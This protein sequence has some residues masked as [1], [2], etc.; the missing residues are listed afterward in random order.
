MARHGKAAASASAGSPPLPTS[1]IGPSVATSKRL[2]SRAFSQNVVYTYG[3]SRDEEDDDLVLGFSR[4]LGMP[5]FGEAHSRPLLAGPETEEPNDS[6]DI[7]SQGGA[8]RMSDRQPAGGGASRP[9]ALGPLFE[10]LG[11]ESNSDRP[12]SPEPFKRRLGDAL[13]GFGTRAAGHMAGACVRLLEL[14]ADGQFREEL[15]ASKHGVATLL[16][17][18]HR[19]R[20]DPMVRSTIVLVIAVA[21]DRAALMQ[22]LVFERHALEIVAEILKSIPEHDVLAVRNPADFATDDHHRC[23]AHICSLARGLRLVEESLPVSTY[24]LALAALHVFTRS[25]DAAFL[26][27]APL[28]RSEMHESGCLGLIAGHVFGSSIPQL[29]KPSSR[30]PGVAPAAEPGSSGLP[31][32]RAADDVTDDMW[33]EFDLPEEGKDVSAALA[34]AAAGIPAHASRPAGTASRDRSVHDALLREPGSSGPTPASLALELEILQFCATA[35]AESQSEILATAGC[36]SAPLELLAMSQQA[37][38]QQQAATET[39]VP[40]AAL[41]AAVLVL[42]LLVNLSNGSTEFCSRFVACDGFGIVA[43]NIVV[44]SQAHAAWPSSP[45]T[46]G[47]ALSPR[48]RKLA[49]EAGDLR[50]DMLLVT[51]ALLTNIV[52]ADPSCMVHISRVRQSPLCRLNKRCFP[53][54]CCAGRTPLVALLARAFMS[55][56]SAAGSAE[57]SIAAGY[58]AVLLGF[59]LR[60]S[61]HTSSEAIREQLPRRDVAVIATHIERFIHISGAVNRRFAGLLGG[62]QFADSAIQHD[63]SRLALPAGARRRHSASE[64]GAVGMPMSSSTSGAASAMATTLRAIIDTLSTV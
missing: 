52:H 19:T 51:S 17:G 49:E 64:N 56:H 35:S 30:L 36:I 13:R 25:D 48:R 10:A 47:A 63:L 2:Q 32:S 14:L 31:M 37:A 62:T 33:M 55:C 12:T 61:D 46:S 1:P 59:L 18:M 16:S 41:E 21:F 43:K 8:G 5:R 54:C 28:L 24:N 6:L 42:Q 3:R 40:T 11:R 15:L 29:V 53:E 57:A 9:R 23:V 60:E 26:A 58:L 44:V 4:A 7:P 20:Q 27:M 34:T 50:Y 22:A 39:A 38:V 45:G